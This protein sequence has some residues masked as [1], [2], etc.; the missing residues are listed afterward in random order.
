MSG[1]RTFLICHSL[2]AGVT[3]CPRWSAFSTHRLQTQTLSVRQKNSRPLWW[4][5]HKGSGGEEAL[6]PLRVYL[7]TITTG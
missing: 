5:G 2:L 1:T 7:A 3:L 6:G 4:M